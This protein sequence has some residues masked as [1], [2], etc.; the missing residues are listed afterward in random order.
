MSTLGPSGNGAG[1]PDLQPTERGARDAWSIRVATVSGIPIRLHFT[2]LLLLTWFSLAGIGRGGLAIVLFLLGVFFCVALHELGHSLVAQRYGYKVR[3]IVLYPIGGVA[4]IEGN[5]RARQEL[6]IALAGPAVNVVIAFLLFAYL[7]A[8]G[9]APTPERIFT[10]RGF[11]GDPL[12]A[13][14][15]ANLFLV[16]FNM[17]PAFP[18][19]GGRVLRAALALRIGQSR[20]TQIAARTGQLFAVAFGIWGF[21]SGQFFL[22]LIALFVYFGAGQEAAAEQGR[23]AV[24]GTV[25]GAAMVREF[26]TLNVG[27]SL[28]RAAEVL[29]STHQQDFPV[30]HGDQVVGV[31]P[32][33]ALLRGLA[34]AGENAYVSEAMTRDVVFAKASDPLEDMLM[35]AD[36]VQRA[37]VLIMEGDRLV[38]MLTAENL[39]EFLTLRQIARARADHESRGRMA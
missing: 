15:R 3:D 35:R 24:E 32:R 6:A 18:M 5:P 33:A 17:I 38:G 7:A 1:R 23:S 36:G 28:R 30:V 20:A 31:L 2:F 12:T 8:T 11:Q 19:D 39:M 22:M 9:G 13:L 4:S 16:L 25:V 29:L 21:L 34:Q 37:P 26:Q 27:D 10:V 14:L